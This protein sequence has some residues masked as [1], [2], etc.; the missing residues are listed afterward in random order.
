[1]IE[2]SVNIVFEKTLVAHNYAIRSRVNRLDSAL[3]SP[4]RS[5][6]RLKAY[7]KFLKYTEMNLAEQFKL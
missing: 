6:P 2:T 1:M 5:K 4:K 7:R 3:R